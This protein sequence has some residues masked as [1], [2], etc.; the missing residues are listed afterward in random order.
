M[1]NNI[2]G[3]AA[4]A[5]NTPS[6]LSTSSPCNIVISN[7]PSQ[8]DG[9]NTLGFAH[10]ASTG[11]LTVPEGVVIVAGP[12]NSV[13]FRRLLSNLPGPPTIV[14]RQ[15]EERLVVYRF[16]ADTLP[17]SEACTPIGCRLLRPGDTL[18]ISV[19]IDTIDLSRAKSLCDLPELTEATGLVER[20]PPPS[21]SSSL[22]A[23][24]L[25]G[26][27]SEFEEKAVSAEPLLGHVCYSGQATVWYAPPNAG[28]TL[29]GLSLL[30]EA[31]QAKRVQP[32]NVFYINAD[33]SSA[34][35]ATKMR[36]MDDL[37]V[38]TLA[39]GHKG[40]ECSKLSEHLLNCVQEGGARGIFIIIDTLKKFVD[41]MNKPQA[42]A[43]AEA[44]RRFVMN[45]GTILAFAHT[46][47][48]ATSTG[49]LTYAGTADIVQDF[50]AAYL[51][52]PVEADSGQTD[53]IIRFEAT[54]RR[55]GGVNQ[56]AYRYAAEDNISYDERIASVQEVDSEWLDDFQHGEMERADAEI[57]DA[58]KALIAMGVTKKMQLAK[59]AARRIRVS[60]RQALKV[61]ENYTGDDPT[62]H[63]WAFTVKDRGAKVFELLPAP[64][65]E[66]ALIERAIS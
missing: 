13:E 12:D 23:F 66:E 19:E 10:D 60:E 11:T 44:C 6:P 39:P 3:L 64:N 15:S 27:A 8:P 65:V 42:S 46:N 7:T 36:L 33:D 2:V 40:F 22:S 38:H 5:P 17:V 18:S 62:R 28:K 20:L 57:I 53:R 30:G 24:S 49:K 55:G 25:R 9:W 63:H 4:S 41:L 21:Q 29:I 56:T 37:G 48:N 61:L 58:I 45:G 51:M 47:K 1:Q 14:F 26:K 35:F 31:V 43:F 59:T 52:T 16:A 32:G 50:D 54:K 34:G